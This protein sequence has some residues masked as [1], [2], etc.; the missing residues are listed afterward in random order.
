MSTK[1]Q[2]ERIRELRDAGYGIDQAKRIVFRQDL[3]EEIARASSIEDI[4]A[5]LFSLVR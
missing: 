3:N 4:K 1:S 5:I 2:L